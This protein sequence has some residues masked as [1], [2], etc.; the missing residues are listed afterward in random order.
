[1]SLE[2]PFDYKDAA[3]EILDEIA[4]KGISLK[5]CVDAIELACIEVAL[6]KT[7][8]NKTRAARLLNMN[9]TTFMMRIAAISLRKGG[10]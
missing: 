6:E 5:A 8:G 7:Q 4:V 9:R 2:N 3:A 1:M 10:P